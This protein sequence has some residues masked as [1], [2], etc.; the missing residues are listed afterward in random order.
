MPEKIISQNTIDQVKRSYHRSLGEGHLIETF[1]DY[2]LSSEK[3]IADKFRDTDFNK[4]FHL[5]KH[6]IQLMIEFAEGDRSGL[7]E[8]GNLRIK[9]DHKHLN[10]DPHLYELWKQ[11]LVLA[12]EEHDD[13]WD[14]DLKDKWEEV[15]DAGIEYMI[16]GY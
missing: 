16:H 7:E 8:L 4:Q 2:F 10:I 14:A 13:H 6:G 11:A 5:L 1:Y 12:L 9:H 3:E 15:L